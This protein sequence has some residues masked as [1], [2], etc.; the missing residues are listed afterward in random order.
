MP[1][2]LVA[3]MCHTVSV[4]GYFANQIWPVRMPQREPLNAGAESYVA[5]PCINRLCGS[6]CADETYPS[7]WPSPVQP[8]SKQ[9][10]DGLVVDSSPRSACENPPKPQ[11]T[12][13]WVTCIS[14]P[15]G[16]MVSYHRRR[17]LWS[18]TGWHAQT[19]MIILGYKNR[20]INVNSFLF[21]RSSK[22]LISVFYI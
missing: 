5:P 21:L 7:K 3:W 18:F 6:A 12:F 14:H 1:C 13:M 2:Q 11:V 9:A 8:C 22:M 15:M 16:L 17:E 4:L 19:Q 10:R 20:P